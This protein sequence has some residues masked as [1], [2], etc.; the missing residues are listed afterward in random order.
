MF[1]VGACCVTWRGPLLGF[2]LFR[3]SDLIFSVT[4]RLEG[5]Q[6][7][8]SACRQRCRLHGHRVRPCLPR[9]TARHLTPASAHLPAAPQVTPEPRPSPGGWPPYSASFRPHELAVR[10]LVDDFSA[11]WWGRARV[12]AI[13]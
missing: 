10:R 3:F 6:Q 8:H 13:Q 1:A 7:L 2:S 9:T 5:Q 4:C 11:D 12:R